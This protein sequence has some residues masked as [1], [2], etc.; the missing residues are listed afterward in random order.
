MKTIRAIVAAAVLGGSGLALLVGGAAEP[1]GV[2]SAVAPPAIDAEKSL[3]ITNLSVIEDAERTKDGGV[4]SFGKLFADMHPGLNV[5]DALKSWLFHWRADQ[6]VNGD[7]VE[8]R[9]GGINELIEKWKQ[10][11]GFTGDEKDWQVNLDHSPFRLTA[12]VNRIDLGTPPE[13]MGV[14]SAGEGRF[15][16][17]VAD[18][19][20]HDATAAALRFTVIFEYEQIATTAGDRMV[21]ATDWAALSGKEFGPEFNKALEKIT[22]RFAGKGA[23]GPARPNGNAIRQVRTN[24][25][26]LGSPWEL[27]EFNLCAHSKTLHI[28]DVKQT[29]ADRFITN[30]GLLQ[31]FATAHQAEI[32]DETFSIPLT[33]NGQSFRGGAS[34]VPGSE[35][36]PNFKWEI[37]G[38]P[39]NVRCL[40]SLASCNGCHAGETK[41]PFT[42]VFVRELGQAAKLSDFLTKQRVDCDG[43]PAVS[44]LER[45]RIF[46]EGLVPGGSKR[47]AQ[48]SRRPEVMTAQSQMKFRVH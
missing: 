27:R 22:T 14:T 30:T 36:P 44:D 7:V 41:T 24:E 28:V 8:G 26:R 40:V 35:F 34:Q 20:A 18:G 42:H 9:A 11:D 31:A 32:I 5:S 10:R 21:W 48:E 13:S 37:P 15:V 46:L 16:F 1:R 25:V 33:F 3:M 43:Q 47:F 17:C 6:L 38:A 39:E 4:W 23:G 2:A 12:I 29:P 19:D 45:R